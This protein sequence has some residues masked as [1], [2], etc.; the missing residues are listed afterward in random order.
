MGN[1]A[2]RIYDAGL[3]QFVQAEA[4]RRHVR[5]S[6]V[7]AEALRRLRDGSATGVT[8]AASAAEVE[9]DAARAALLALSRASSDGRC[10]C[11]MSNGHLSAVRE[12]SSACVQAAYALGSAAAPVAEV[13]RPAKRRRKGSDAGV[14]EA[15]ATAGGAVRGGDAPDRPAAVADAAPREAVVPPVDPAT[16]V[17]T[18]PDRILWPEHEF[19]EPPK[20]GTGGPIEPPLVYDEPVVR[21]KGPDSGP[22]EELGF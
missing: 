4:S 17:V 22:D 14:T 10:W 1:Y 18:M 20:A 3:R 8:G 19:R 11:E 6:D 5:E 15:P 2:V 9:R 13:E 16:T 7:V 12:H 21:E